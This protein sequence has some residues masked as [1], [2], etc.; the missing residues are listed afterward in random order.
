MNTLKILNDAE[1]ESMH[2]AALRILAEVGVSLTHTGARQILTD[3][4]A[5]I[6][7]KRTSAPSAWPNARPS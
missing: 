2:Q 7:N 3:A 5:N 1:V 4:G 6:R